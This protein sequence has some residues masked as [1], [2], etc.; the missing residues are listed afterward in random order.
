MRCVSHPQALR[1]AVPANHSVLLTPEQ[2]NAADRATVALGGKVADL[3]EQAGEAVAVAIGARW[4]MR[5]VVVLCGPGGNGG[6]GFVAARHLSQAGWPVRLALLGE[7]GALSG[8]VALAAKAWTGEIEPMTEACL[9]GAE[10]VLDALFGAG[11]SRPIEGLARVMIEAVKA[12][13][14][15]ACAIDVPCGVHGATGEVLGRILTLGEQAS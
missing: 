1:R 2:A 7:A 14:M 5:P 8:D 3:M 11:L 9:A 12:R 10:I 6:D 15:T 13:G 4:L